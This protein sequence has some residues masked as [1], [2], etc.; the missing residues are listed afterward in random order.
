MNGTEWTEKEVIRLKKLLAKNS[1]DILAIKF[2]RTKD[3]I[4]SKVKALGLRKMKKDYKKWTEQEK[5]FLM[6]NY[7]K[8]SAKTCADRLNITVQQVYDMA[9]KEKLNISAKK[10]LKNHDFFTLKELSKTLKI[11]VPFCEKIVKSKLLKIENKA[12]IR[13]GLHLTDISNLDKLQYFLNNFIDIRDLKSAV[14]I[15]SHY[16]VNKNEINDIKTKKF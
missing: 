8:Y 16:F 2:N 1:Y 3:S 11:S 6:D 9:R 7:P 12:E 4:K 10:S 15:G 13:H 14:K 5:H